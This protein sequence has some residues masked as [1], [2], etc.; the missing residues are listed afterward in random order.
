MPVIVAKPKGGAAPVE[1]GG[2]YGINVETLSAAKTLTP[3]TDKIYQYLNPDGANRIITLATAGATA[4]DRFVIRHNGAANDTFYLE[5]KQA[6]VMLDRIFA[7]NIKEFIFDGTNWISR[8]IGT[9]E[10]NTKRD[11]VGIGYLSQ[12][13]NSGVALGQNAQGYR[14]G[15]GV[16]YQ[17]LGYSS[18][19]AVGYSSN[20]YSDGVAVGYVADGYSSGVAVGYSS[21]GYNWGVGVGYLARTNN[22]K[23]SIALGAYS[24]TERTGETSVNIDGVSTQKN[25]V[26]QGRWAKATANATPIEMFCGGIAN[27]RFTI[28]AISALAFT[29]KIVARDYV[30]GHVAMWTV[31]DGLIKRDA[32]NNTTMVTC[33]VVEVADESTDWTVA[34]TADDT[35]ESLKIT[36]TGD[37]TNPTQFAAVMDGVE[38]HF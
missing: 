1:V 29:M 10:N 37:P 30:A 32:A 8:G 35:Y 12:A 36:V 14:Y 20:G 16:G 22:K 17:G 6:A 9:G 23:F 38:T 24:K 4:G 26:V 33:T 31:A 25:N 2:L 18:G 28:R 34:V 11:Q 3:N 5:V 15:V 21:Q 13:Y 27:Q 19:V 7:G